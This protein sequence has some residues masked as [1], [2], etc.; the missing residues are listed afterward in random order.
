MALIA[1]GV[2]LTIAGAGRVVHGVGEWRR[3]ARADW[4]RARG[5]VVAVRDDPGELAVRVRYRDESGVAH[6]VPVGLDGR[7]GR[8]LGPHVRLRYD[9][10]DH[11]EVDLRVDGMARPGIDLLLA[12]AP[13][14]AGLA[15]IAMAFALWRRRRTVIASERPV[16][17]ACSASVVGIALLFAGLTAWSIGTVAERG[18]SGVGA[19]M[20]D[21]VATVFAEFLGV[22]IP[23]VTFV[24]GCVMTVW[25]RATGA[26]SARSAHWPG[27][28]IWCTEPPRSRPSPDELR[29]IDAPTATTQSAQPGN[30]RTCRGADRNHFGAGLHYE[31][32]PRSGLPSA[33]RVQHLPVRWMMRGYER[34]R[35]SRDGAALVQSTFTKSASARPGA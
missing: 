12:G 33:L 15:G 16:V 14:G 19:S 35:T 1:F 22:L 34:R 18:W 24:I 7:T 26:A 29:P 32:E 28:T 13:L 30:V 31:G 3:D 4:H 23:I 2:P 21:A 10:N 25:L 17:A 11:S 8:W 27:P 9:T 20:S 5:R 6:V